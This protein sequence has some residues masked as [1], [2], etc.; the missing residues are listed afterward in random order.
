MFLLGGQSNPYKFMASADLYVMPSIT[1]GFPNALVEAMA[2]GTAVLS[3]DCKSGPREILSDKPLNTV[4]KYIEY[5]EAGILVCPMTDSRDYSTDYE[6]CDRILA[7]AIYE[8]L[9]NDELRKKYAEYAKK[10][11]KLYSYNEFENNLMNII[12]GL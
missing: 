3:A 10:R 9:E 4:C 2:T 1:E 12:G 5:A 6:E 7:R 11:V 8:I